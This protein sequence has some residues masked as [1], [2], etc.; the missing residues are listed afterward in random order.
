MFITSSG[1]GLTEY[2]YGRAL[3]LC[4]R[5]NGIEREITMSDIMELR[6]RIWCSIVLTDSWNEFD[7]NSP[8]STLENMMFFKVV[9]AVHLLCN[10]NFC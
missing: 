4:E 10:Y 3:A 2:D 6:R 9:N 5:V 7:V 8:M 1:S